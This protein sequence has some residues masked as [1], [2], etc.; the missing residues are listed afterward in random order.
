MLIDILILIVGIGLLYSVIRH[1][2]KGTDFLANNLFGTLVGLIALIY[3]IA[4]LIR[5]IIE[6]TK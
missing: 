1:P 3:G 4:E 5:D 6:T 2:V